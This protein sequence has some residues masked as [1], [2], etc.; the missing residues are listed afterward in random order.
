MP[1]CKRYS[2]LPSQRS[3]EHR[4]HILFFSLSPRRQIFR[5][6]YHGSLTS[7]H[8]FWRWT[9][10]LS[11]NPIPTTTP[12]QR[13]SVWHSIFIQSWYRRFALH[14]VTA[15]YFLRKL[16]ALRCFGHLQLSCHFFLLSSQCILRFLLTLWKLCAKCQ[17]LIEILS[18]V[19]ELITKEILERVWILAEKGN[20]FLCAFYKWG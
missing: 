20:R 8:K 6:R 13:Q 14:L 9:F 7:V 18:V 17:S 10:Q 1:H 15:Y 11:S 5:H 2:A 19:I 3:L 12:I 4:D 16:V